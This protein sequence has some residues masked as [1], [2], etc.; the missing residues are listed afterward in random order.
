[1]TASSEVQRVLAKVERWGME[2]LT[3][4]EAETYYTF[5]HEC[6]GEFDSTGNC[7]GYCAPK[8]RQ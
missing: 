5:C 2:S 1:M 4:R 8:S 3:A 7:P 6:H